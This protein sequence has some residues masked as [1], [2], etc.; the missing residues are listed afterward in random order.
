AARIVCYATTPS[1]FYAIPLL[2][3]FTA[4]LCTLILTIIGAKEVYR[5]GA[6]RALV[7]ALFSKV[8]LGTSI[9]GVFSILVFAMV[10]MFS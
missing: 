2:G 9:V 4:S 7:I 8:V 1:L 6:G 10:R 5:V 3:G